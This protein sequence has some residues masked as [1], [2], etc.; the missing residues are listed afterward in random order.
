MSADAEHLF[1][2]RLP[3]PEVTR[4][5]E[6][7]RRDELGEM[8]QLDFKKDMRHATVKVDGTTLSAKLVDLPT[9][10]ECHKTIESRTL[11]KTGNIS[12]VLVCSRSPLETA[13]VSNIEELPTS[14]QKEYLKKFTFN[15]GL[16]PPLKNVRRRRFKKMTTKKFVDSPEVE[17]EVKRL[18]REDLNAVNVCIPLLSLSFLFIPP[19]FRTPSSSSPSLSSHPVVWSVVLTTVSSMEGGD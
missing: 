15:H 2:L 16:T 3:E 12:Q 1:I 19:R 11:Y 18:L 4:V 14:Q 6:A 9:V 5:K 10:V 13:A 17:K 8:L 7:M